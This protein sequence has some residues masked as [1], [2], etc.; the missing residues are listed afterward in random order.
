MDYAV[1]AVPSAAVDHLH[2]KYNM[3]HILSCF[4]KILQNTFK[5]VMFWFS[6]FIKFIYKFFVVGYNFCIFFCVHRTY[7]YYV[8]QFSWLH[9][10]FVRIVQTLNEQ[11]LM[12][13]IV[14]DG[15]LMPSIDL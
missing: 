5:H 6:K 11:K 14:G 9:F 13:T 3:C 8:F 7:F 15:G 12:K 10:V 1:I 2:V 4:Y